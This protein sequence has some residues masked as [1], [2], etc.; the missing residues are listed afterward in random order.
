VALT[1]GCLVLYAIFSAVVAV[2]AVFDSKTETAV[3]A[4]LAATALAVVARLVR[5]FGRRR[6]GRNRRPTGPFDRYA[7]VF[8][9]LGTAA[10]INVV[11]G[12]TA[13]QIVVIADKGIS[14]WLTD[15]ATTLGELIAVTVILLVL[16]ALLAWPLWLLGSRIYWWSVGLR[17][18]RGQQ[19]SGA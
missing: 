9:V 11:I 12:I 7:P 1:W 18:R 2:A 8:V 6:Y 5:G 13:T 4:G 19:R 17:L 10:V 16:L 3:T 15:D 14:G